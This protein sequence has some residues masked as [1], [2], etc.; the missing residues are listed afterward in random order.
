VKDD[1]YNDAPV[2]D[3]AKTKVAS[4]VVDQMQ[5]DAPIKVPPMPPGMP[6]P[7][8]AIG[9]MLGAIRRKEDWAEALQENGYS[10]EM[11]RI[12]NHQQGQSEET[13]ISEQ[14]FLESQGF[15]VD[16]Q[17]EQGVPQVRMPAKVQV[18]ADYHNTVLAEACNMFLEN[19]LS[20]DAV[21]Q[22]MK[23]LGVKKDLVELEDIADARAEQLGSYFSADNLTQLEV[24][25]FW[26]FYA[27][28][29][30]DTELTDEHLS[31]V[32]EQYGFKGLTRVDSEL[33]MAGLVL[34]R[35]KQATERDQDYEHLEYVLG[36]EVD[37]LEAR[38][39]LMIHSSAQQILRS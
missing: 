3:A 30:H 23:E 31:E 28:Y 17:R 5:D 9:I 14:E 7:M 8:A 26:K 33:I 10:D 27:N 21:E 22:V 4:R 6:I 15:G 37:D 1:N 16:W 24:Q 12:L 39:M 36:H 32:C 13:P 35:W 20:W 2:K 18:D 25:N 11:F 38:W 34:D 29:V 19:Y